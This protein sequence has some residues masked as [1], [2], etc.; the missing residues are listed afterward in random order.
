[1]SVTSIQKERLLCPFLSDLFRK[2]F[3]DYCVR[4]KNPRTRIEYQYAVFSLC[5]HSQCDFLN[6]TGTQVRDFLLKISKNKKISANNFELKVIRAI[7]RFI[8]EHSDTYHLEPRYLSLFADLD[9]QIPSL[10]IKPQDLPGLEEIDR[11]LHYF[12]ENND[13]VSFLACS[14]VLRSGF[15]TSELTALEKD[16]FLQDLN[17][18]YGTRFKVSG[19][20]YRYVKIPED[21]AMLIKKYI[22]Q[23]QDSNPALLLN[24]RGGRISLR[25]LQYH[26]H[27]ACTACEVKPFT[28]NDL[29]SL[30]QVIMIKNGAPL[31]KV[32]EYVDVKKT[33]WFFKYN[34]AVQEFEDSAVDYSHIKIIW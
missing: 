9:T 22:E 12:K 29:R 13:F 20:A 24:R 32:A 23:R 27:E 25:T 14:L 26:L 5:N 8:D 19:F 18:N 34:R 28:F 15:T 3:D 2:I 33:D 31:E 4:F 17:G 16:M 10:H 21:M 7:A 30:S 11:I 6:L 1:M